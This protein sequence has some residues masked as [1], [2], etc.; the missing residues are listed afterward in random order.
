MLPPGELRWVCATCPIKVRKKRGQTNR[1]T[2]GRTDTRPLHYTYPRRGRRNNTSD[3][4]SLQNQGRSPQSRP[5]ASE[6]V[7]DQRPIQKVWLGK[8]RR[9]GPRSSAEG[10]SRVERHSREDRGA[11]GARIEASKAP[12]GWGVKRGCPSPHLDGVCALSPENFSIFALKKASFGAFWD[13]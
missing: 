11:K 2:D 5:V 8:W 10:A 7:C 9:L 13:W 6:R 12:R 1:R 3:L 4:G